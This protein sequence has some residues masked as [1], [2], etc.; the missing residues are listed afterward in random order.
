MVAGLLVNAPV[1]IVLF[2]ET[3]S[4][5]FWEALDKLVLSV[6]ADAPLYRRGRVAG[7]A[8]GARFPVEFGRKYRFP[9]V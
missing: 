3:T 8:T 6:A 2:A 1:F 4:G 7:V 5:L 9:R